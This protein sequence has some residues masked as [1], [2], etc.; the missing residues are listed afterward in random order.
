VNKFC[1][2]LTLEVVDTLVRLLNED[3]ERN[4]R[5]SADKSLVLNAS[6]TQVMLTS[7]RDRG[8]V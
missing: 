7:R 4:Y 2:Q 8:V 6:K 5:W 1:I 3:L